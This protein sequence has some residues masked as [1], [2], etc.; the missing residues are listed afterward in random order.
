M[1]YTVHGVT[2]SWIQ[3]TDFHFHFFS[4]FIRQ[5]G[6]EKIFGNIL[7]VKIGKTLGLDFLKKIHLVDQQ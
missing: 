6:I 4:L 3:L 5:R 2:K 7:P 1:D